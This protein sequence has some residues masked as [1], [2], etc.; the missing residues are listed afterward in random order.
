MDECVDAAASNVDAAAS[1]VE[2]HRQTHKK[3]TSTQCWQ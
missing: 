2:A 1:N 3:E